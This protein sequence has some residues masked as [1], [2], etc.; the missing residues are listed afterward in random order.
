MSVE[1]SKSVT[2]LNNLQVLSHI[3]IFLFIPTWRHCFEIIILG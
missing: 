2:K 3:W 1:I